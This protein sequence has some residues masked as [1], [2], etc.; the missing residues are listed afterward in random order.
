MN[1]YTLPPRALIIFGFAIVALFA[2]FY[3]LLQ[4]WLIIFGS[5]LFAV[6]LS[7]LADYAR[8]IPKIGKK[9]EKLSQPL[10]VGFITFLLFV[11]VCA[12]IANF[13]TDLVSQ[14]SD[15]KKMIPRAIMTVDKYL[16]GYPAL[17]EWLTSRDWFIQIQQNPHAFFSQ[18]S[19]EAVNT[20]PMLLSKFMSG[21][22]TFLLIL[23]LGLF[24]ALNPKLYQQSFITLVPKVHRD[25]AKYLL[26]RSYEA[27]K[28]WL[29]GQMVVMSFVGVGTAIA[30]WLM[31][32]PFALALGMIAF[33]ADFIPVI[34]PWLSALPILLITL[35]VAPKMLLWVMVMIIVVQQ[36]ESYV[37]APLVQQR[38]VDLPPV[39]LLLSQIIMG[40][41][42][43]ILGIALAT[44]IM[45]VV[46]VWSQVLYI[47]F[48]LGDYDIKIMGQTDEDFLKDRYRTAKQP[49]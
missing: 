44:P 9:L 17:Y 48:I 38:L 26:E 32:V 24:L 46:I 10:L 11:A 36:I 19:Q 41:L 30:L 22:G 20:L 39:A 2:S 7:G 18:Y 28:Q 14:F 16:Q 49:L 21:V 47:K 43:G 33:V 31:N 27:L 3:Y 23:L 45:V 8:Q 6:F 12:F 42:T 40:S 35:I 29:V 15:I 13:G 37:L 5:I 1:Q 34:G 4:V 25:K